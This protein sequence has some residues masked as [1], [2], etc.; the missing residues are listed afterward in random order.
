MSTKPYFVGIAGGSGSGKTS[1]I[2]ALKAVM[3]EGS[4]CVVSQDDYYHPIEQQVSDEN[5]KVNFDLFGAIDFDAMVDD[6]RRLAK[7]EP[8]QRK[9]YTFNND[10][11]EAS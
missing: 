4:I 11:K 9:E 8:I 3:P 6:L 10:A 7:G 5:G 2:R 1:L